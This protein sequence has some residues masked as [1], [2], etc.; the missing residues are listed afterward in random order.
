MNRLNDFSKNEFTIA[1]RAL[2]QLRVVIYYISLLFYPHPSR[3]NLDYDFPL[4]YSL[5]NPITTLPSLVLI[6]GL[7][8]LGLYLAKKQRLISFCIFWFLGNLVVESSVIPLAIIFEHRLYMPSMLVG[9]VAVHCVYRHLKPQWLT[10]GIC[11]SSGCNFFLLDV[12]KK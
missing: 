12:S 3:L 4:S 2:T 6:L 9:L 11:G 7:V 8:A 1:Q 5:I 10:V